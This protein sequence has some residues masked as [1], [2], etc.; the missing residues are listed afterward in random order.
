[1]APQPPAPKVIDVPKALAQTKE[2]LSKGNSGVIVISP[3]A[4]P[5]SIAA[6]TSL[7]LALLKMGK[8]VSLVCADK[9]Q[10]DMIGV[11]K[12]QQTISTG[13]N[14]LV[15]SFPYTE[16]SIDDVT[17]DVD[18]QNFYI[19]ITPRQGKPKVEPKEVK[20]RYTGGKLDFI[21]AIDTPNPQLLGDVYRRHPHI[22]NGKTTLINIDRHMMN[23]VWGNVNLLVRNVSSTSEIIYHVIRVLG[24][25]M[26]VD[27]ATNIYTGIASATNN[28]AS[29][30]LGAETFELVA[31]LMRAGAVRR[32]M[33]QGRPTQTVPQGMPQMAPGVVPGM[34]PGMQPGVN[35]YA[36]AQM[37]VNPY[38]QRMPAGYPQYPQQMP[39]MP[40]MPM[41]PQPYATPVPVTSSPA[42]Q[43]SQPAP[44][45]EATQ[46][47]GSSSAQSPQMPTFQQGKIQKQPDEQQSE[48]NES[49]QSSSDE[50]VSSPDDNDQRKSVSRAKDTQVT[51]ISQVERKAAQHHVDTK[52]EANGDSFLKP[53]IFS[54]NGGL[55]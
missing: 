15:I 1:M 39:M 18:P 2:F 10:S 54:Q 34:V 36:A 13:G 3:N 37:G 52:D 47:A 50:S 23:T 53:K 35:P 48:S 17:Y 38:A 8:S 31:N 45:Q 11:D 42:Q 12:F 33:V 5:D 26:D 32:Q 43:P 14:N 27:I 29:M 22:F 55:V 19:I 51:P 28:F 16:G 6:A 44:Q 40:Q 20:F 21:V 9:P 30:T 46:T 49:D 7:Y 41:Q 25:A 24:V 4:V